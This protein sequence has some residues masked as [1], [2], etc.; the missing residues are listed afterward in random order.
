MQVILWT[1]PVSLVR[2]TTEEGLGI[3]DLMV[4]QI[5]PMQKNGLNSQMNLCRANSGEKEKRG[6]GKLKNIRVLVREK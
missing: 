4:G 6:K 1:H 2:D 3:V 5:E